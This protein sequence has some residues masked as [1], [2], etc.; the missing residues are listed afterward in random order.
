M[1]LVSK[2][3][4]KT[5]PKPTI[6]SPSLNPNSLNPIRDRVKIIVKTIKKKKMLP[7]NA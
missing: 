6:S 2:K 7:I 1:G 4:T 3:N 5:I